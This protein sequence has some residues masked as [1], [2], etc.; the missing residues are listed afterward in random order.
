M[1][2]NAAELTGTVKPPHG[3]SSS[4]VI[5]RAFLGSMTPTAAENDPTAERLLDAAYDLFCRFGIQRTPMEKVAKAAGVTRV[6][7]YRK[8][9][10]KDALVDEVVLREFR[11]YFDQFRADIPKARTA[12]DRVVLG[13][14]GSL[15]AFA[16]NPLISGMAHTESS[17]LIE[18]MIGDDGL[19]LSVVQQFVAAQLR[20]EQAAGNISADLD[21]E[22]VAEMFVRISASFLTVPS[23]VVDITDDAQLADIA[24]RFLVPMLEPRH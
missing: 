21:A 15:R 24:R 17:M 5:Q 19:L 13:F 16:G 6:T 8:F 2:S 4:S 14:V 22:L 12:A 9:A 23:R 11:R 18:S 7:L 20:R 10:T 3:S 1:T